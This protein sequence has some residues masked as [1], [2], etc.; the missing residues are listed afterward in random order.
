MVIFS[1]SHLRQGIIEVRFLKEQGHQAD[2]HKNEEQDQDDNRDVCG[3]GLLLS[4]G[5][6]MINTNVGVF[7]L[8][9]Q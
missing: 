8:L 2:R 7:L 4:L 5:W 1:L 6:M 9:Y 3:H